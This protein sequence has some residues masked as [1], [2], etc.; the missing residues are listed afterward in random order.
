MHV[1]RHWHCTTEIPSDNVDCLIRVFWTLGRPALIFCYR[2][3]VGYATDSWHVC[4]LWISEQPWRKHLGR[5]FAS[6]QKHSRK[7]T[8]KGCPLCLLGCFHKTAS[9]NPWT[10]GLPRLIPELIVMVMQK[11]FSFV[12]IQR[13][14][15]VK[16][17]WSVWLNSTSNI[18]H[19]ISKTQCFPSPYRINT[20]Q[21][22]FLLCYVSS[23]HTWSLV[24]LNREVKI[25]QQWT[26]SR[27]S[28]DVGVI[29]LGSVGKRCPGINFHHSR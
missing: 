28:G 10:P 17:C 15:R 26:Q 27:V 16:C 5:R 29:L 3:R 9:F 2:V 24:L 18:C 20:H 6:H 13:K 14:L 11:L 4:C 1:T 7:D 23:T 19:G 8:P 12:E 21:R 22:L 25:V